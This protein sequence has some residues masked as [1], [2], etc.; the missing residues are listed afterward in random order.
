MKLDRK[1]S[2]KRFPV[3]AFEVQAIEESPGQFFKAIYFDAE[4]VRLGEALVEF[5]PDYVTHIPDNPMTPPGQWPAGARSHA[6]IMLPEKLVN[7]KEASPIAKI[8]IALA[9]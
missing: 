3:L 6:W 2:A 9:F 1:L 7:G 4:G 5:E 8:V